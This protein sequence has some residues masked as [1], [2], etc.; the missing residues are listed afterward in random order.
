MDRLLLRSLNEQ[1]PV[2]MIYI[3]SS[4]LISQRKILVTHINDTT[5]RAYCYLR[6]Q[7]RLFKIEN[8]LS[9]M[10]IKQIRELS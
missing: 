7:S 3:S 6:K 10:A 4:N 2:E 1:I 8:I 5:I 9:I